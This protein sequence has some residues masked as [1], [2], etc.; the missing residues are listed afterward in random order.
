VVPV[1]ERLARVTAL[2]LSVDTSW[3]EVMRAAVRAGP[4]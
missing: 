1:V 3:P 2:P 4:A